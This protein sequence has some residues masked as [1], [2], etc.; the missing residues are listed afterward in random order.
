MNRYSKIKFYILHLKKKVK[1]P[2]SEDAGFSVK[3]HSSYLTNF[4]QSF[5]KLVVKGVKDFI[6]LDNFKNINNGLDI[7]E[8]EILDEL[9]MHASLC[10]KSAQQFHGREDLING[11]V[12]L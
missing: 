10:V 9:L 11:V 12:F 1:W 4:G 6:N 8:D 2:K 5:F 3:N 7:F